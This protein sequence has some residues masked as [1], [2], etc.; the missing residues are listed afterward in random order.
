MTTG[1]IKETAARRPRVVF[2]VGAVL[3]ASYKGGIYRGVVLGDGDKVTGFEI[4]ESPAE[5]QLVGT[6]HTSVGQA[7]KVV[8][9]YA[10]TADSF[11]KQVTA[12]EGDTTAAAAHAASADAEPESDAQPAGEPTRE[13]F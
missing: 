10:V 5:R 2:G 12:G 3:Q 13:P 11:W 8:C 1:A 9:G 7:A 6:K 4:T